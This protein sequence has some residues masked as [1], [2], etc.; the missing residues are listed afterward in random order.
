MDKKKLTRTPYTEMKL[1]DPAL[2][3]INECITAVNKI[4]NI[5]N[6]VL[7]PTTQ[8]INAKILQDCGL[9]DVPHATIKHA[10][11]GS[12]VCYSMDPVLTPE[13]LQSQIQIHPHQFPYATFNHIQ[14]SKYNDI[15]RLVIDWIKCY[16]DVETA[17]PKLIEELGELKA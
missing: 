1:G 5:L 9:W 2:E 6:F 3:K 10:F 17:L 15:F 12:L 13:T 14:D 8:K 16:A 4:I 11:L 7:K